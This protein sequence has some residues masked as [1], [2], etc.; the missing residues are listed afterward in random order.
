MH[1]ALRSSLPIVAVLA[2]VALSG[3]QTHDRR[4]Y[5]T[6]RDKNLHTPDPWAPSTAKAADDATANMGV[7][8]DSGN[9]SNSMTPP[10]EAP[11]GPQ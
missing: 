3:C 8:P 9:A 11:P 6:H 7:P 4:M 5:T 10:A 2:I 1:P